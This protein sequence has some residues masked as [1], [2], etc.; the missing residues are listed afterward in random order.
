MKLN[1]P[2]AWVATRKGL[3]ELR[4]SGSVW[5]IAGVSFLAEPV[6]MMLP[7]GSLASAPQRMLAALNLGHFGVKLHAS[8]DAGASWF[9]VA[10]PTYPE[11]PSSDPGVPWKMVQIWAL[12]AAGDTLWCGTMPGGLF[13]SADQGATWQLVESLWRSEARQGWMGGGN[14]APGM[15]SICPHPLRPAELL[16][17]ISCGGVW[18]TPDA[19]VTWKLKAQ[20]ML[21]DYMPPELVADGNTQDPHRIVRCA[22]QPDVLWCQHHGGIWCST[23][24]ADSWHEIKAPLSSFG[25]AVAVHPQDANTAWF[26]PAVKDE[27]RVPVDGALVVNRTRDGGQ[28]FE[29]FRSGLPQQ[30]AYDLVYRHG[31]V[32]SDDGEHLLMGST[33][34][35]LW[36]SADGGEHWQSVSQNLPP[37][38][39]VKFG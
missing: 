4:Y 34:G 11:Q 20:G 9:E 12:E 30:H 3:F 24:N 26:V 5:A 15:H 21:A 10:T 18:V 33:T 36:A 7:P 16:T 6:T 1:T 14:E 25:F 19:G 23:N 8:D 13:K 2:R 32:V 28:S 27:K 35:G 38:Y 22:A 31:L 29:S 39:A 37:I 17:A